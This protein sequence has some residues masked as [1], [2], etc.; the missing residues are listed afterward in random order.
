MSLHRR[1]PR[2]D[3]NERAIIAALEACGC[4]VQPLSAAGCPD[5]LVG[6][7]GKVA[8]VEVKQPKGRFKPAQIAW[9]ENWRGPAP[10]TVRSVDEAIELVRTL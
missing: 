8:L 9:R 4:S 5:L 1:N 3:L 2:R 7:G 6:K 10:V